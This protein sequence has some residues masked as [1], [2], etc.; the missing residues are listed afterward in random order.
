MCIGI[1][2]SCTLISLSF[3]PL[4]LLFPSHLS[5][6]CQRDT[7]SE[8]QPPCLILLALQNGSRWTVAAE[9][10]TSVTLVPRISGNPCFTRSIWMKF[11][12]CHSFESDQ[13][14][15][16]PLPYSFIIFRCFLEEKKKKSVLPVSLCLLWDCYALAQL[17][18]LH[19]YFPLPFTFILTF[20]L[21][22]F[23]CT[24]IIFLCICF[25]ILFHPKFYI[26]NT[27]IYFYLLC[28]FIYLF[29][30]IS[31]FSHT[32]LFYLH[33]PTSK[34]SRTQGFNPQLFFKNP[35]FETTN[36]FSLHT[37]SHSKTT[38][39]N[40]YKHFLLYR[41]FVTVP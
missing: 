38:F 5:L 11:M 29:I 16:L 32:K 30:L 34:C 13:L 36:W 41:S 40:I 23:F 35:V 24:L 4:G 33:S 17:F 31:H 9:S 27:L 28:L 12:I 2:F 6:K 37:V 19:Y 10:K 1:G 14:S 21:F 26:T 39:G 3:L 22:N 20:F 15:M 8:S 18:H 7:V 25:Q